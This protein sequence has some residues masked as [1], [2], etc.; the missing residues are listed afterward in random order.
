M[1][2]NETQSTIAPADRTRKL[3][4]QFRKLER[5]ET[6]DITGPRNMGGIS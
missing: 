1:E 6:S 3:V 5:I 2:T 4:V